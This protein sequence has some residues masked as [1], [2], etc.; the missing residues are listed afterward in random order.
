MPGLRQRG[1]RNEIIKRLSSAPPTLHK[2]IGVGTLR[3]GTRFP[4]LTI[5]RL[6][7]LGARAKEDKRVHWQFQSLA[8]YKRTDPKRDAADPT[9]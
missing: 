9:R 1:N 5:T 8:N 7:I 4:L 6:G 3:M 2:N